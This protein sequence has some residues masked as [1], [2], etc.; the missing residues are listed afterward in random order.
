MTT[1]PIPPNYLD[2]VLVASSS[3]VV[4]QRVLASLNLGANCVEHANGGAEAL[5]HLENGSWQTLFLDKSLP[6]L[7][8]E[9]LSE[10]V[11]RRY[12]SVQVVLVDHENGALAA[13]IPLKRPPGAEMAF[14]EPECADNRA[15][16]DRHNGFLYEDE[17]GFPDPEANAN[18]R[19]KE[20][21][22][23]IECA[24]G[25]DSA[26]EHSADID[27]NMERSAGAAL[28]GMI[29]RSAAMQAVYRKVQL[30]APRDTTV[31]ITGPTGSGKELVARALHQLSPRA[32][33]SFAV[34]NCAAISSRGL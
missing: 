12:P 14:H 29:G 24:C 32:S 28:P 30:V 3:S 16:N 7:N 31:L 25:N 20:N 8:V 18:A 10:T 13:P 1:L 15:K 4:R 33:R 19:A 6:D 11:R 2:H 21:D 23:A 26:N 5:L 22:V 34:V 27:S 17:E 9:E